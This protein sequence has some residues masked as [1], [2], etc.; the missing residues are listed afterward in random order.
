MA[1]FSITHT[2]TAVKSMNKIGGNVN[3]APKQKR[4]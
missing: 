4:V 3:H 2:G 1:N